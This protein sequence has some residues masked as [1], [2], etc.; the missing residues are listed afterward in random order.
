MRLLIKISLFF[1]LFLNFLVADML[2]FNEINNKPRSL[3][4]DYYIFRLLSSGDLSKAQARE[5][6]SEI[7]RNKGKLRAKMNAFLGIKLP[8]PCP[9]VSA[10]NILS[11]SD[12]CKEI[13]LTPNFIK[14]LSKNTISSLL[15]TLKDQNL[16]NLINGVKSPNPVSYFLQTNNATNFYKYYS[17]LSQRDKNAKFNISLSASDLNLIASKQKSFKNLLNDIVINGYYPNLALSL[18]NLKTTSLSGD[19]AFLVGLSFIKQSNSSGAIKFFQK[20]ANECKTQSCKDNSNFWIYLITKDKNILN[21]IASSSDYNIYSLY[22]KE[23]LG[24]N[25]IQVIVPNPKKDRAPSWYDYTDPFAFVELKA[26]VATL[27]KTQIATL[28][29]EFNTKVTTGEYSYLLKLANGGNYYPLGFYDYLS[30][31]SDDRKALML[32]IAR[33][34]SRF[35]PGSVSI[36]YALGMMQFMPF[37]A[38]E[39]ARKLKIKNFDPDDMFNPKTA[40]KFANYHIDW[41]SKSLKNPVFIAYAYNGGIGFTKKMLRSGKLFRSG[42]FEPFLSMELVPYSES[43]DYGKKVLANYVIYKKILKEEVS[44]IKII[45]ELLIPSKSYN[46]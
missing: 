44:I 21:K 12:K 43:R 5:L 42:A 37:V 31:Y 35:I 13:K 32:A 14:N 34:E 23:L 6:R 2:T 3:A 39:V 46:I 9:G 45:N 15:T 1:G 11:A 28:A 33:Q 16:I 19:C 41:T 24:L 10:K 7:Y 30:P 40:Y 38:D 25:N 26:K 18:A 36:S 8:N 27:N 20:S 22:A 17:S 29:K 4:K